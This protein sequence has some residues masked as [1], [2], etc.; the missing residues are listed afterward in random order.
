MHKKDKVKEVIDK[1][2]KKGKDFF[3]LTPSFLVTLKELNGFSE[4]TLKRGRTEYKNEHKELKKGK[5]QSAANLNKKVFKLLDKK[6]NTTLKQLQEKFQDSDKKLLS[7][8]FSLWKNE[9]K[10]SIGKKEVV[11]NNAQNTDGS[12]RQKVFVHLNENPELTLSKLNKVFPEEN[13]KT[14]SNYLDQWRKEK[15]STKSGVSTRQR[16]SDFLGKYPDSKLKD[17]K[18]AFTDINP[19]SIGAYLSQWK[20]SQ[21]GP[22]PG[23]KAKEAAPQKQAQIAETKASKRDLSGD[24]ANQ[25]IDALNS[26]INAQN[27]TIEIL[28]TQ[29]LELKDG[30]AFSFPELTG[31]TKKE[32]GKFERVMATFLKG[33]RKA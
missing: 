19:S 18:Q 6:P 12:L 17:L 5:S 23:V 33:L 27:K 1:Y 20:K 31:M 24:S 25:I 8:S 4:R 14:I 21:P 11:K 30:Q 7:D 16:I 3:E 9:I 26:T 13:K 29:N 15:S 10:T 32:I 28:K 2:V 22:T